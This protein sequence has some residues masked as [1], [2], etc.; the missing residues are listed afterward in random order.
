MVDMLGQYGKAI[1]DEV[2]NIGDTPLAWAAWAG[3]EEIVE[4][5]LEQGADFDKK[6]NNGNTALMWAVQRNQ[7]ETS[8]QLLERGARTDIISD[9]GRTALMMA[10]ESSRDELAE[11]IR[12]WSDTERNARTERAAK[13]ERER[14]EAIRTAKEQSDAR[15]N[16]LKKARPTSPFQ[17]K[18]QSFGP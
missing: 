3:H 5:L 11:M 14:L 8:R 2:C 6:G 4:L 17:K 7:M 13:E 16:K 12:Y 18:K 15:M 9:S 1:I 10:E